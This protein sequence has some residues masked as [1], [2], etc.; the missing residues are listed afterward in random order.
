[1]TPKN[2]VYLSDHGDDE[3]VNML[4]AAA[5]GVV[6]NTSE[7]DFASNNNP[8]VLRG[9]LKNK[10]MTRCQQAGRDFYYVD[11]GY[12]GNAVSPKNQLG[13]K[14]WHRIVKNGL[15]HTELRTRPADRLQRVG[16]SWAKQQLRGSKII[17]AA[18]DEKPCRHY[19]IDLEA[20][21]NNTVATLKQHTDR[22]I[23]VR[24]RTKHR[25]VR[26]RH[27][28]LSKVL[29]QDVHALVTF[30]SN[31]AVESIITGVPAFVLAPEHAAQPV[32]LQDLS[33][34]ET[35]FWPDSDLMHK[36]LCHLSY[37]QFR[38]TELRHTNIW[39]IVNE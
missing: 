35:P 29:T 15:Q 25:Q 30:N 39:N 19:G 34:I 8:I 5:G 23:V 20:W 16:I 21:I 18:P 7:F 6:T 10:I 2:F 26:M 37:C 12:L 28:P 9:I 4:A 3:Y 33:M 36:W 38:V 17:V 31:A 13:R 27:D 22:E 24:Q 11:S 14:L 32:S 1:M